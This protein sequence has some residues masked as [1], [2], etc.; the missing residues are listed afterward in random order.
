MFPAPNGSRET[1]ARILAHAHQQSR[2]FPINHPG[3]EWVYF[4]ELLFFRGPVIL[5]P[6]QVVYFS[7][8]FRFPRV[9][10]TSAPKLESPLP[11]P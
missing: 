1:V 8:A 11:L 4:S 3:A 7:S 9:T 2:V 5:G 6:L 10:G